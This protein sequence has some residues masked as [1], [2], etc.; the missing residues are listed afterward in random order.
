MDQN[1]MVTD[2]RA[3]V[4][5][6]NHGGLPITAAVWVHDDD[7][8]AWKLWIAP[9]QDVEI[10]DFYIKVAQTIADDRDKFSDLEADDTR[11]MPQDH[12]AI[13]GLRDYAKI[14]GRKSFRLTY[15]ML[16]GFYLA[17]GIVV[18]LDG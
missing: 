2:G 17:D 1:Q 5:A 11:L 7:H 13:R 8:D 14:T 15:N 18:S 10:K 12:P 4:D 6:L 9:R 16:N 3:L